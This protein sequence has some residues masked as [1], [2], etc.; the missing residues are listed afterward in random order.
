MKKALLSAAVAAACAA[1]FAVMAQAAAPAAAPAKPEPEYTIA[2]NASLWSDYRFRGYTQTDYNPAFQ[3]GVDFTHKSGFYL[4][5]WNSN[6]NSTLYNGAALE[7]DFYGGYKHS[8]GDFTLDLGTI[9][10]FYPGTGQKTPGV[11]AKNW[12]VYVGGAYGPVSLKYYYSFTDY[13]G[14]NSSAL[15]QPGSTNSK[16]SSYLDLTAATDFGNG[17][18]VVAHVGLQSVKNGTQLGMTDDSV[19]DYKV[20][21]TYDIAGSGWVVGGYIVG[22]SEKNAFLISDGSEGAGKTS[23]V[24]SISKTF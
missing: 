22:T 18:G 13:F 17:V 5:N 4:G 24:A 12:E 14:L 23:F 8:W 16:G 7:M 21:L 15:G 6:V 10:Y 19:W 11:N 3:G 2:G 1:P 9:Y 20:G